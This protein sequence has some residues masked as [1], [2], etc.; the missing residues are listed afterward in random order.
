MIVHNSRR[1][2]GL[3]EVPGRFRRYAFAT[4]GSD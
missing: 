3:D 4:G 1:H 2:G